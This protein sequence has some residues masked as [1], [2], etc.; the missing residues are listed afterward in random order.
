MEYGVVWCWTHVGRLAVRKNGSAANVSNAY[1]LERDGLDVLYVCSMYLSGCNRVIGLHLS[2]SIYA[3][4]FS[5][6]VHH[7]ADRHSGSPTMRERRVVCRR[8]PSVEA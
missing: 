8:A 5:A 7:T 6:R 2:V 3:R 4:S 1:S